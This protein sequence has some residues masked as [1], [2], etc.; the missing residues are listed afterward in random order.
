MFNLLFS[1]KTKMIHKTAHD[2]NFYSDHGMVNCWHDARMSKMS[3]LMINF[4]FVINLGS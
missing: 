3:S 1:V 2:F 4:V